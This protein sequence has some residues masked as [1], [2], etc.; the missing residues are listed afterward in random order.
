MFRRVINHPE[1]S[2][3]IVYVQRSEKCTAIRLNMPLGGMLRR[4]VPIARAASRRSYAVARFLRQGDAVLLGNHL[5]KDADPLPLLPEID[6]FEMGNPP[7]RCQPW[8]TACHA[9]IFAM[10]S[11]SS[12]LE[13]RT[14]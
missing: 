14:S 1:F 5:V 10:R 3:W 9:I 2:T 11:S 7:D 13:A 8:R 12:A 4:Q 6:S